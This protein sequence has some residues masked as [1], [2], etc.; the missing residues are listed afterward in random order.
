MLYADEDL[1]IDSEKLEV[2][3]RGKPLTLT[4]TERRLLFLLAENA[5]RILPTARILE[6]VWGSEFSGQSDYVKL[7]I[8]RLRQKIELQPDQPKYIL[9]ERGIGYRFAKQ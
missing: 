7:Y 3:C 2:T 9:T 4:A 5:G 8:W 1:V 6:A